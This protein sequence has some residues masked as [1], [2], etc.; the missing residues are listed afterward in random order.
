MTGNTHIRANLR[1]LRLLGRSEQTVY[2]RERALRRLAAALPVP[3]IDA[4]ADMLYE[5]RASLTVTNATAACYLSHV[6][7]FYA[8]AVARGLVESSPALE[9]PVPPVPRRLP[10]PIAEADLMSAL[11]LAGRRVRLWLV[12]AAWCGLR[13]KE[14]ALLRAES[15]RL[16]DAQP[17]ILIAGNAT[18][19]IRERSVPL[20]PFAAGE[21]EAA[22]LPST[23]LA[24]VGA[25]GQPLRPWMVSKVCNS[26]LHDC[27]IADTLHTLRHRFGS[28]AYAVDHDLRQVQELMG[29]AHIQTTAGYAAIDAARSAQIVGALPVPRQRRKAG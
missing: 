6:K 12:L 26:H 18:K 9:L 3:L 13:A 23:G 1:H 7:E 20:C 29:H 16:R 15:I 10:R 19:G 14:I 28:Q 24:F 8:W 17:R 5:W 2:H 25:S 21:I 22:G 27:G 4:D 11:E